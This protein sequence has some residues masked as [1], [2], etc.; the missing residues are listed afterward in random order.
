MPLSQGVVTWTRGEVLHGQTAG[1]IGRKQVLPKM[2]KNIRRGVKRSKPVLV[3]SPSPQSDRQIIGQ[4]TLPLSPPLLS[5]AGWP[6][7]ASGETIRRPTAS[8]QGLG[9]SVAR[10]AELR[11][12]SWTC[13]ASGNFPFC[14]PTGDPIQQRGRTQRKGAA[15]KTVFAAMAAICHHSGPG[16]GNIAVCQKCQEHS[17]IDSGCSRDFLTFC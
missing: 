3:S 12:T 14:L 16:Q 9:R 17:G 6:T 11:S 10:R 5:E 13:T 2:A 4:L 1:K 8:G 7:Q 15:K